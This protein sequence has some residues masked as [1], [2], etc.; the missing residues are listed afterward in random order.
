MSGSRRAARLGQWV[1][2]TRRGR[3]ASVLLAGTLVLTGWVATRHPGSPPPLPGSG[4]AA[5]SSGTPTA[6]TP[7]ATT[8][9]GAGSG[10]PHASSTPRPSS[11]PRASSARP[12]AGTATPRAATTPPTYAAGLSPRQVPGSSGVVEYVRGRPAVWVA[13]RG[14][15]SGRA[16]PVAG[17]VWMDQRLV[18]FV[19]HPGW[20]QPGHLSWWSQPD[21][22][23]PAARPGLLATFNS[24]FMLQ[25]AHGGYFADGR[26]AKPLVSGAASMVFYRD[27]RVAIGAWG[28]EVGMSSQVVAVRQNLVLLVD[29]GQINPGVDVNIESAWGLTVDGGAFAVWRSG[30]GI[31]AGGRLVYVIGPGLTVRAVATLLQQAGAVRAMQLDVNPMWP[32][33]MW[34]QPTANPQYPRPVKILNFWEPA[35]RYFTHTSRDFVAV[36]AR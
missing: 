24:G 33:Y 17:V 35:D 16:Y 34:Y 19:Q 31:T 12:T 22:I 4:A 32:S 10:S 11:T 15:Y 27:G 6:T 14:A 18:R 25:D 7:T 20:A 2:S 28:G 5:V 36:Y 26:Y 3:G 13:Y 1:V 8:P 30:V 9:T 21:I 23:V 29:H